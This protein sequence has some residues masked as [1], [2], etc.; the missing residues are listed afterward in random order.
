MY[1]Y[2]TLVCRGSGNL[3]WEITPKAL[4][5]RGIQNFAGA[6]MDFRT[7][8]SVIR[9]MK[10]TVENGLFGFTIET[11]EYR[12]AVAW[13]M[14]EMRGFTVEPDW[15]VPVYGT[16]FSV[17]TA[18]RMATEKGQG[19]IVQTPVYYRYQSAADHLGR[20]TVFNP[21][22]RESGSYRMDF[23]DLEEKM[24]DPENRL[25]VLCNPQNPIGR[26]WPAEDLRRVGELSAKYGVT[27]IS[28]EIFGEMTFDGHTAVPYVSLP[29]GRTNAI[30]VVSLGKAFNFTGVNHA[31]VIIPDPALRERYT[32]QRNADHYGSVGPLEYAAVLGAYNEEGRAWFE[33]ARDYIAENG[34]LV[35][36]MVEEN[37]PQAVFYPMEGTSVCWIDWAF[38][39]MKGKALERFFEEEALVALEAGTPYGQGCETFTRINVST[40]RDQ[41]T[42]ALAR[43]RAAVNRLLANRRESAGTD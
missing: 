13:W 21:L 25:L 32:A 26:V 8:P 35:R 29:E 2:D 33:G 38:L 9:S 4:R 27:V 11:E 16:I 39:G 10:A 31:N 42:A 20:K 22:I 34:R 14:K 23:A 24:R 37:Y 36:Q 40:T 28:D 12:Q 15:I 17:A 7:A 43:M 30:T 41:L 18:L 1:D 5:E 3:K 6:E 19:I